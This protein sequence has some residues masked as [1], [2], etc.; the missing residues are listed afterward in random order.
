ML[1]SEKIMILI[2]NI[3]ISEDILKAKFACDL[4]ECKGACCT[5]RGEFGAPL[6]DN[7]IGL[8]NKNVDSI[9]EYL[10]EKSLAILKQNGFYEG[11]PGSYSTI[12][13]NH[14]DCVFVYYE[15]DI[16][17]CALEKGY[18]EG[19]SDFRKPLSCHLF[20]IRVSE[21][22]GDYLYYS[23]LD[24]CAPAIENGEN[25][26]VLMYEF[27]KEALVRAYG[28]E[29]YSFLDEYIKSS[30]NHKEE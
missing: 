5:F 26:N 4:K 21:F 13:I 11:K 9:K 3:L 28:E 17:K 1:K 6:L 27:V 18:F 29:W 14:K 16:A 2:D 20:P 25:Q 8:I 30:N 12:C 22:S 15:G 7:E 24:E 23:R 19:K 10:S